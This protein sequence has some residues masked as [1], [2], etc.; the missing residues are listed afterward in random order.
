MDALRRSDE[1]APQQAPAPDLPPLIALPDLSIEPS[2]D[3]PQQSFSLPE[4]Q[5]ASSEPVTTMLALRDSAFVAQ[6]PD[7]QPM[8]FGP[9]NP[10]NSSSSTTYGKVARR[11]RSATNVKA[12]PDFEAD[13]EQSQ[14]APYRS[15][16]ARSSSRQPSQTSQPS[17]P[18]D[19]VVLTDFKDQT[20]VTDKQARR[21]EQASTAEGSPKYTMQTIH[22][23]RQG[24]L[25]RRKIQCNLTVTTKKH[26][27]LNE[28]T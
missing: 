8:S 21:Q 7:A 27:A 19:T 14:I 6:L 18:D 28:E 16:S 2:M 23:A 9:P 24:R 1:Q 11:G 20:K 13:L 5:A 22:E 26:I 15:S 3:A 10:S 12:G 25:I 17:T 4:L